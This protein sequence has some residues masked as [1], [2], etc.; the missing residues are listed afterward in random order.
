MFIENNKYTDDATTWSEDY[1]ENW[2]GCIK[3]CRD[4]S[5]D[6][7]DCIEALSYP[8]LKFSLVMLAILAWFM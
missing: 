8:V 2:H 1:G 7:V 3:L 5:P 4:T 6:M